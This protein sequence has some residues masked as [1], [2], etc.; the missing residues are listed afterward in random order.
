MK[1]TFLASIVLL[2]LP[3]ITK[4]EPLVKCGNPGQEPC[5]ICHLFQL[6]VDIVGFIMINLVPAVAVLMLVFAGFKLFSSASGNPEEMEKAKKTMMT[7]VIG[8]ILIYGAWII[9]NTIMSGSG[10]VAWDG[11]KEGGWNVICGN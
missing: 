2:S 3:L 11:L 4:A 8:L 6:F 5:G 1:K 10:L 7:I 9:I